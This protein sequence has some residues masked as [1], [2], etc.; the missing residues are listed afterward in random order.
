MNY[1]I[2]YTLQYFPFFHVSCYNL[3]LRTYI[4]FDFPVSLISVNPSKISRANFIYMVFKYTSKLLL[5]PQGLP[6]NESM[7]KIEDV[8]FQFLFWE[9]MWRWSID[10]IRIVT[11]FRNIARNIPFFF[12]DIGLMFSQIAHFGGINKYLIWNPFQ[13]TSLYDVYMYI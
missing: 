13:R 1:D 9:N 5:L 10:G 12:F 8:S 3:Y 7:I 11:C 2:Y 4:W 6:H